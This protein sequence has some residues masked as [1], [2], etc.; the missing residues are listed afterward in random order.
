MKIQTLLVASALAL[1]TSSAFATA[2]TRCSG[3]IGPNGKVVVSLLTAEDDNA[4]GQASIAVYASRTA[5]PDRYTVNVIQIQNDD[6]DSDVSILY[7]DKSSSLRLK[8]NE[9]PAVGASYI[10][11]LSPRLKRVALSCGSPRLSR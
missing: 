1:S 4:E 11:G 3:N 8:V 10:S 7:K 5:S 2:Q 6:S 9:N